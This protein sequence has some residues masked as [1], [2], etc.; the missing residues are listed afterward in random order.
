LGKKPEEGM[1]MVLNKNRVWCLAIALAVTINCD[2]PYVP[3]R[4]PSPNVIGK[5]DDTGTIGSGYLYQVNVNQ[6][7]CNP[8]VSQ[9]ASFPGCMLWL[10][11]NALTVKIPPSVAGYDTATASQHDRL[12]ISDTGNNVRWFI[13]RNE[14]D[15]RGELQDPEWSTHHDYIACLVGIKTEPFSGY[16][17]R[18]SDKKVLKVNN[19]RLME[20]STPHFWLPDSIMSCGDAAAP[21]WDS[22]GFAT[23]ATIQEFFGTTSL[24]FIYMLPDRGGALFYID[25]SVDAPLPVPLRKPE[26][27]ESWY[28]ESPLISPDGNW[29]AYHVYQRGTETN[30]DAYVS[31]V[32]RLQSDATPVLVAEKASDPHWWVDP[33]TKTYYIVYS[34][35]NGKYFSGYRYT[36]PGIEANGF[37][38]ATFK[39]QLRGSWVDGPAHMGGL[40]ADPDVKPYT[41]VKLPF[42]GGLSRDG[43]FLATA[44]NFAYLMRLK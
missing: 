9:S 2:L 42:K 12:T 19:S 33:N 26:G 35:T 32:Q 7:T 23:K 8:S 13:M 28:A 15:S 41:L 34:V 17:I 1:V 18:L 10:G 11:F 21:E 22:A 25:Y 40:E 30:G 16:A 43:Y 36:D 29:V 31:Y 44:Y 24:K 4:Q 38:G 5:P 6:Q 20:F 14:V 3:Q 27:R 37:A 39:Q